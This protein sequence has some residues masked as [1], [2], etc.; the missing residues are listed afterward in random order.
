MLIKYFKAKE[1]TSLAWALMFF[2]MILWNISLY[3]LEHGIFSLKQA[4]FLL[5]VFSC[6]L[7][8]SLFFAT[9]K[10]LFGRIKSTVAIT[11][12]TG[13]IV[14]PIY[15][16]ISGE[17]IHSFKIKL[18]PAAGIISFSELIC[19]YMLLK[20]FKWEGKSLK[21][22]SG[23]VMISISMFILGINTILYLFTIGTSDPGSVALALVFS[24]VSKVFFLAGALLSLV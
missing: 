3:I 22:R 14:A 12:I 23:V 19:G 18:L 9:F 6:Y 15:A 2:V 13:L 11:L 5:V 20:Y 17:L 21:V 10:M 7:G 24:V 16:L 4:G 8:F 1:D